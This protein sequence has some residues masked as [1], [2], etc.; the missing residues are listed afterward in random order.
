MLRLWNVYLPKQ[1]KR[2]FL[3]LK[4]QVIYTLN[5]RERDTQGKTKLMLN[6]YKNSL[7]DAI[8]SNIDNK[9]PSRKKFL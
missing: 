2:I 7:K 4:C 9:V 8:N 1:R 5:R 6:F 3:K